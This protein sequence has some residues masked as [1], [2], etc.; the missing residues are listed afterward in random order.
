VHRPSH[1]CLCRRPSHCTQQAAATP[2]TLVCSPFAS[3]LSSLGGDTHACMHAC[4]HSAGAAREQAQAASDPST[5]AHPYAHTYTCA[6]PY[7]RHPS[8]HLLTVP[9][10]PQRFQSGLGGGCR[11][12]PWV[13]VMAV[14][15][16]HAT[17]WIQAMLATTAAA[18]HKPHIAQTYMRTTRPQPRRGSTFNV[19]ICR[20]GSTFMVHVPT[21][22][23][24]RLQRRLR[25]RPRG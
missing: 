23:I 10:A 4:M 11:G 16:S 15:T 18:T 20:R 8:V 2:S 21:S 17:R 22:R 5:L 3:T 14:D 19:H 6:L 1:A 25:P 24:Q 12:W 7:A 13:A 9:Q